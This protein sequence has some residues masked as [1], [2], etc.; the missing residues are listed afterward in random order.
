MSKRLTSKEFILKSRDK[1][2]DI[3]DYSLVNYLN[4]HNTVTIIC[5][6][7]G[8]FN[9]K[10]NNHLN[11]QGCPACGRD[12]LK[13]N[14]GEFI[15]RSKI[16]HGDKYD[17]SKSIYTGSRKLIK[18]ICPLHLEFQ[19]TPNNHLSGKGCPSCS[20]NRKLSKKI[21]IE[22]SN[23]VHNN[24]YSYKLKEVPSSNDKIDI[25]CHIHGEFKQRV[26]NHLNGQG[27]PKCKIGN[28]KKSFE[29][30]ANDIHN[31]KYSYDD[32]IDS[33]T[34]IDIT[35]PIHG[36]FK[37]LPKNHLN[38][39]HGCP[40]C[41]T[42]KGESEVRKVLE[43]NNI[44]Y[45]DQYTFE[46]CINK[47][48]LKFDFYLPEHNTC[49]EYD[50]I[51]HFKPINRFGGYEGFKETKKRDYIKN[52]YCEVNN[53]NLIRISYTSFNDIENIVNG[54]IKNNLCYD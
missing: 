22:K 2:G 40:R 7:H 10:P 52:E 4:S 19:Q 16:I 53:I 44:E 28:N 46:D 15:Y 9:M 17:Y 6:N 21:F 34:K 42:S 20:N 39:S 1:H 8:E 37:Q 50:G 47:S 3:Y 43:Q 41:S 45:I 33:H 54:L 51:Q 31:N 13:K 25:I 18:I 29:I 11:G 14:L 36:I 5:V 38:L 12:K 24:T 23:K 26:S 49:I 48:K 35:C 32:Y 30:K 27:C